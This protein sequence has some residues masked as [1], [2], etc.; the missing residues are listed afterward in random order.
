MNQIVKSSSL[1]ELIKEA[2]EITSLVI[3]SSG[4]LTPELEQ[5]LA[6]NEQLL[7]QKIDAYHY[8]ITKLSADAEYLEEEAK[9]LMSAAKSMEFMQNLLKERIKSAIE[10]SGESYIKGDRWE[11]KLSHRAPKLELSDLSKIPKEYFYLET[12]EKLD[13]EKLKDALL[14]NKEVPGASFVPVK[15]LTVKVVK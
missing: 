3:E 6:L 10:L 9:K 1:I 13:K 7:P 5:R 2:Q 4:V 8:I 14:A 15:A 11:F 12:T